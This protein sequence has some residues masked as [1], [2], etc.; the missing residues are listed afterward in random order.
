VQQ[1]VREVAYDNRI[2]SLQPSGNPIVQQLTNPRPHPIHKLLSQFDTG[3]YSAGLHQVVSLYLLILAS[4]TLLLRSECRGDSPEQ[5]SSRKNVCV[6][7]I[8]SVPG[9]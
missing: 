9:K 1:K 3:V 7:Y 6:F 2:N 5:C 8:S 4:G